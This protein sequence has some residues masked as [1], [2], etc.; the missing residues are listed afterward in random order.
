MLVANDETLMFSPGKTNKQTAFYT[1]V[2][3]NNLSLSVSSL[4]SAP[5]TSKTQD[6]ATAK[7]DHSHP[8]LLNPPCILP[9]LSFSRAPKQQLPD[10]HFALLT[11]HSLGIQA[12]VWVW[13]GVR[14][15]DFVPGRALHGD[16]RRVCAIV[17]TYIKNV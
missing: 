14:W 11:S 9:F 8:A 13:G 3:L 2:W 1:R 6:T 10:F 5:R 15:G 16:R 12:G 4:D 7:V 17:L